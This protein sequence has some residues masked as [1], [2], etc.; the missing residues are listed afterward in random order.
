MSTGRLF[1][2]GFYGPL[3]ADARLRS[4]HKGG[5]PHEV[6]QAR[7]NRIDAALVR[8]AMQRFRCRQKDLIEQAIRQV[9]RSHRATKRDV[10]RQI[11]T[12]IEKGYI[13]RV[14]MGDLAMI[15]YNA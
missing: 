7:K 3:D 5:V 13:R 12:L 8:T 4:G 2:F 10:K 11:H 15:E 6:V 9:Q 1:A 14:E